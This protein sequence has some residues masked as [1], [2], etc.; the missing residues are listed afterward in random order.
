MQTRRY[1]LTIAYD[2]RP[3]EGWQSQPS[4]NTVQDYLLGAA[5]EIHPEVST[6]QGSGRTDAGVHAEAQVAHFDVPGDSTMDGD[7]WL[8]ALNTKLPRTIRI[9]NSLEVSSEFHAQF[10]AEGK[11]Y[12]YELFTGP[13][14]PP[15][16]AGLAWHVRRELDWERLVQAA[17]LFVG[18]HD[19]A[20]FAANRGDPGSNPDNTIRTLFEVVPERQADVITVTLHGNGFLYKMVRLIIGGVTKCAQGA[21]E[22][23]E[24]KRLLDRPKNGEKS[25]LAAP[26][27]GL[28][29][30]RVDYSEG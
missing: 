21:I 3:F 29:L 26:P 6:F 25:P 12:R 10:D 8:R 22:L 18:E 2:G 9:M 16:R 24:L 5:R 30:V 23:S 14:L 13:V 28:C 19:F 20:A 4:G 7:A 1:R 27:D 17:N 11:T 15:L